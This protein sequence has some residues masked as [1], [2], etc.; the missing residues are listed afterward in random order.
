MTTASEQDQLRLE[1]FKRYKPPEFS[2]LASKD[3]LGFLDDCYRILRTMDLF[4]REYVP[5]SLR[6]AWCTEF[7]HLH[8]GAMTVSEY[9]IRY[10]SLARH[11]PALV[12]TVRERVRR[13]IEG[14][15]PSIRSS[16]A[17]VLEMDILSAALPAVSSAPS[18][19]RPQQPYYAPP[20]SSAPSVR[21]AFRG[22]HQLKIQELDIL[23]TAFR[24]RYGHYEFLVMSFGL[25]NAPTTFMHLMHSVFRP[26]LDSFVIVFIDDI[27]VYSR[28]REDHE[29]HLR[30]ML[31]ALREKKLYAK[32]SKHE[33]WMDSMAFLGHVVSSEGIRVDLKKVEAVQGVLRIGTSLNK[34]LGDVGASG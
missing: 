22:Y 19:P 26:Y 11:A 17:L 23:K 24:T 33:F 30:T 18:P 4:L 9:V 8:Q 7:E 21:G 34:V 2:G 27:L 15:I 3:A 29:Q 13:F 1:R 28:S 12:A 6:N 14:L 25:T 10:T 31:Q 32:F 16:M 5:Q 20:V